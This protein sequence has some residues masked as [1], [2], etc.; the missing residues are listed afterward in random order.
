M[1]GPSY[2]AYYRRVSDHF[3][4]LVL[5]LA[6]SLSRALVVAAAPFSLNRLW[7]LLI[8]FVLRRLLLKNRCTARGKP[9][10][11]LPSEDS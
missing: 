8:A 2:R 11:W 6:H 4:S 3:L 5:A 10:T 7:R 9:S 1:Q